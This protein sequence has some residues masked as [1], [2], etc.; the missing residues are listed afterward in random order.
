[1]GELRARP[2]GCRDEGAQGD[3]REE[4]PRALGR[5]RRHRR[6]VRDV[7]SEVLVSKLEAGGRDQEE[8]VMKLVVAAAVLVVLSV[9]AGSS[10]PIESA[11]SPL[12]AQ[13]RAATGTIK[14]RIKLNG[15]APGNP[16]IRM[17]MDPMCAK[18]NAG[19]RP[20]DQIV[21]TG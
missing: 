16:V 5:R 10:R 4:R 7:S 14:G 9:V 6:G 1:M 17:G 3:R 19:K 2:A 13:A 20:I 8:A 18:L 21:A 11:A 12:A 15:K